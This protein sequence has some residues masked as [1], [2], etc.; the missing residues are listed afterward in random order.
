[1]RLKTIVNELKAHAPFTF[2]GALLGIILMFFLRGMGHE[3]AHNLFFIFHPLHVLLSALATA[4]LYKHYQCPLDRRQCNLFL[5]LIIGYVGSIGIATLS[6]S[7]IPYLG[8]T[9][10]KMPDRGVHA[11]FIERPFLVNSMAVLRVLIAYYNP[12]IR[13]PHF[14]H[15]LLSTAASLLH[16]VM[17]QGGTMTLTLYLVSMVFLFFSVWLPCCIS[18]IVFPLLFVKEGSEIGHHNHK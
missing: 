3:S 6:D 10:L 9:L 5:L 15:I 17:A 12:T 11:G 4:G 14:G 18:D 2:F 13:F 7:L 16:I 1:M 8:E